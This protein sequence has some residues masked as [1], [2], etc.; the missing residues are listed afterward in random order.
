[1]RPNTS[2]RQPIIAGAR[3]HQ[4]SDLLRAWRRQPRKRSPGLFW[5]LLTLTVV[6]DTALAFL[7]MQ[8]LG[9]T[10][11]APATPSVERRMYIPYAKN[12]A[13]WEPLRRWAIRVEG[14]PQ[15][16][17]SF[18]RD[19]VRRVNGEEHFEDS[20]PLAVVVSWMLFN[21]PWEEYPFLRCEDAELRALLYCDECD[22]SRLSRAEQLR[23][24]H[25]EPAVLRRSESFRKILRGVTA[26]GGMEEEIQL[27]PL[28]RQAVELNN[29]LALFDRICSGGVDGGDGAEMATA[30]AALDE[31][32]RSGSSDQF[33]T[34]LADFLDASC[35]ALR[36][37]E[38]P[39]VARRLVWESWCNRYLP[40]RQA[41]YFSMLAAGLLAASV[42][43][44][45]RR[46]LW[47]RGF[48]L[49]GLLACAGCLGWA[50]AGIVCQAL[51][52]DGLPV[53]DGSEGIVWASSVVMSLGFLL[54]LLDRDGF[55]ALSGTLITGAGFALANRWPPAFAA[56]WAALPNLRNV[57]GWVRLHMLMRISAYAALT[58]AWSVAALTL[59]RLVLVPLTAERLHG[60]ARL[61]ARSLGIAVILLATSAV[62]DGFRTMALWDSWGGWGIQAM[63]T[64]LIL[65][66][67]AALLYGRLVGWIQ[68][69]GFVTG[70]V[71]AFALILMGWYTALLL[72]EWEG[73]LVNLS[74][75]AS[76]L[77][78][79][80]LHLS[81]GAH[82]TLRYYFGK[83]IA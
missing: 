64:L 33:A 31:A 77:G 40:V 69:F 13:L 83:Q 49:S 65:P 58:L 68:P 12:P 50:A 52:H 39:S 17:E 78:A 28:E 23:D 75:H 60:L 5:G 10:D 14:Q 22:T 44:G 29:R 66:C 70:A 57:D 4:L 18:C 32:Y 73:R 36:V 2:V 67:C 42:M 71:L 7:G 9:L 51:L 82:A 81:L 20:D 63:G 3:R 53:G 45:A 34:A 27:S 19:A 61:C 79:G 54:A 74:A 26:K 21:S 24:P 6:L 1:M 8:L 41:M 35:R 48:L 37:N 43:A 62:L 80:L 47:R 46:P 11:P 30:R 56:S 55:I 59:V 15:L 25:V 38:D 16:F 72:G 76:L